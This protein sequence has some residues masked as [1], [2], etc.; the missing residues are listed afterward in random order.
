MMTLGVPA[1]TPG[2]VLIVALPAF[3]LIACRASQTA[4]G[5]VTSP[6]ST[7]WIGI[8]G[9]DVV[10]VDLVAADEGDAGPAEAVG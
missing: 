8:E 3:S 10:V 9:A 1:T 5:T 4:P 2:G 7:E 6:Q